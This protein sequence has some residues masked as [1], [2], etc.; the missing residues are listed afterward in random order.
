MTAIVSGRTPFVYHVM[1]DQHSMLTLKGDW[2]AYIVL[3]Y[4]IYKVPPRTTPQA[5]RLARDGRE[6]LTLASC[7]P[8]STANPRNDGAIRVLGLIVPS[9][10]YIG[11][12]SQ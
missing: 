8:A 6:K 4:T 9:W 10:L 7:R 2:Y 12:N 1:L 3:S 5:R 11:V